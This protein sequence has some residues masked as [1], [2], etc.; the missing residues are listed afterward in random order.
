MS[1][2]KLEPTQILFNNYFYFH[3]GK[4]KERAQS[5]HEHSEVSLWILHRGMVVLGRLCL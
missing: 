3:R 5:K 2:L 4:R 1:P